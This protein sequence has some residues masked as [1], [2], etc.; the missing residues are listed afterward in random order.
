MLEQCTI[1]QNPENGP[2]Q[3]QEAYDYIETVRALYRADMGEY[4][5]RRSPEQQQ[6]VSQA[7]EIAENLINSGALGIFLLA[8]HDGVQPNLD[9]YSFGN[10]SFK[11]F[12]EECKRFLAGF[13]VITDRQER[14]GLIDR[15]YSKMS[16]EERNQVTFALIDDFMTHNA[17]RFGINSS[18][19]MEIKNVYT[20]DWDVQQVRYDVD[21]ATDDRVIQ[22]N[23]KK[24]GYTSGVA[25]HT[26]AKMSPEQY[27]ELRRKYRDIPKDTF[28]FIVGNN[29]DANTAL[30]ERKK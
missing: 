5:G 8:H 26:A 14:D 11:D 7:N 2:K 10:H 20:Q 3:Y 6:I 9:D 4:C 19:V 13:A 28:D 21:L 15:S 25:A 12:K 1:E 30:S 29:R 22:R 23:M 24:R 18:G 27:Q 16:D 17:L